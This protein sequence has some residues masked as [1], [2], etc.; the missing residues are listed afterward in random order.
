MP[1]RPSEAYQAMRIEKVMLPPLFRINARENGK[2]IQQMTRLWTVEAALE[3]VQHGWTQA[4]R[5]DGL[6]FVDATGWHG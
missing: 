4:P 2:G 6:Q 1:V 3:T 5:L